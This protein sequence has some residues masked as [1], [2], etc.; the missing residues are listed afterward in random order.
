MIGDSLTSFI[1]DINIIIVKPGL[2]M[3]IDGIKLAEGSS[4]SNLTVQS[5]TS[6]PSSPNDG[7]LF[8]RLDAP[9]GLFIYVTNSWTR[10]TTERET[11]VPQGATFPSTP[12]SGQLF[13]KN[14]GDSQEGLY[15]YDAE[16]LTWI[17]TSSG[18]PAGDFVSVTGDTMEGTLNMGGNDLVVTNITSTADIGILPAQNIKITFNTS[19]DGL[20][21]NTTTTQ[22][23][24]AF[25][26]RV[27]NQD[28]GFFPDEFV[29]SHNLTTETATIPDDAPAGKITIKAPVVSVETTTQDSA[30]IV[31]SADTISKVP[32]T[33]GVKVVSANDV[34]DFSDAVLRNVAPPV[35]SS[36]A[37]NLSYLNG[38]FLPLTGGT[39]TGNLIVNGSLTLGGSLV[40]PDNSTQVTAGITS[41][42][43]VAGRIDVTGTQIDLAQVSNA[44]GG[45]L[46]KFSRDA[47][48][49][50]TGT[51]SVI[52]A[53]LT[54]ILDPT[55]VNTTGDSMTGNLNMGLNK[56][57]SLADPTQANDAVNKSYVDSL[58]SGFSWKQP[59]D[60]VGNTLPGTAP[61]G[62]RFLNLSDN[63]IYTAVGANTFNSGETPGDG[64]ALFDRSTETGYVFSG[65][66]WVQFTG[67]GQISA[68]VGL[69]KSGNTLNVNLGAGISELPTDEIG[70]DLYSP[71]SGALVLTTDGTTRS[72]SNL[73]KLHLLLTSSGGLQQ[74]S[75]GLSLTD[76]GVV[77][78]TFGN[79]TVDAKG[80]ISSISN[81]SYNVQPTQVVFGATEAGQIV[82]SPDFIFANNVLQ[83]PAISVNS[84]VEVGDSKVINVYGNLE[85]VT[86]PTNLM[87][88]AISTSTYDAI[89]LK[90]KIKS[91]TSIHLI[92]IDAVYDGTTVFNTQYGE[93]ITSGTLGTFDVDVS[94]GNFRL[95]YTPATSG[96]NISYNIV[97]TALGI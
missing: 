44:G 55:Y 42:S 57:T 50:V 59:V 88:G 67:A 86:V 87:A 78:G 54:S 23:N 3:R 71:S 95:M 43:G 90:V 19:A 73:A 89:T 85:N 35:I 74:G 66:A 79:I 49:R 29:L 52:S 53:D 7:E 60:E 40:F 39:L 72:T 46:L 76:T 65:T 34:V 11:V 15:F 9:T 8:F 82:S 36:D 20:Q 25:K 41:I 37:V 10:I 5:G 6:F 61:E 62:F 64:W 30:V 28:V 92:T 56:V 12:S 16:T 31:S 84:Y 58:I 48:G 27:F 80:R 13:Y 81:P 47:Y 38:G 94:G 63:K 33:L 97:S 2:K 24:G 69:V 18:S 83:V 68:G 93:I 51:S 22:P 45:T 14:S 17:S 32:G 4:I 1:Y 21:F 75:T 91:G 77:P 70:I 26:A 96:I